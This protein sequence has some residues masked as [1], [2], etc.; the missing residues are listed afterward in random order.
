MHRCVLQAS[1]TVGNMLIRSIFKIQVTPM[2]L[3]H[4]NIRSA[5]TVS[6]L[7]GT[8]D[9]SGVKW[10]FLIYTLIFHT[11][12]SRC[13]CCPAKKENLFFQNIHYRLSEQKSQNAICFAVLTQAALFSPER[14]KL[15]S[16]T[17]VIQL[18]REINRLYTII[19]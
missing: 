4:H 3:I 6:R 15:I 16:S 13:F 12:I 14:G 10:L 2:V 7:P 17:E 8:P 5:K 1:L 19:S 11:L 18:V 9:S